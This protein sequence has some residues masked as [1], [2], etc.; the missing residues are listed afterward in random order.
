M[1]IRYWNPIEEADAIRHQLDRL[2]EGIVDTDTPT[3]TWSPAIEVW[4]DGNALV[5][6]AFLPNVKADDL[7]IKVTRSSVS[8]SGQRHADVLPEGTKRLY[9]DIRYGYFR[10]ATKLPAEVQ[11]TKVVASFEQ[12]ILNLTLPKV[13]TEINKVVKV[14]LSNNDETPAEVN[15]DAA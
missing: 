5:L 12:G 13:E 6:K 8:L 11:N 3:V 7:D 1:M 14:N 15:E 4:D 9:S 10:R 2:F